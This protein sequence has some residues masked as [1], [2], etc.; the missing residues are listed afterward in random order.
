MSNY[1]SD[2]KM[3]PRDHFNEKYVASSLRRKRFFVYV[4]AGSRS[5]CQLTAIID[6]AGA[7]NQNHFANNVVT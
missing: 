1:V 7:V 2:V 6:R 3:P 5:A 4:T